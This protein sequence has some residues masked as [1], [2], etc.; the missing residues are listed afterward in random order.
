MMEMIS[1]MRM[2]DEFPDELIWD[3]EAKEYISL[4]EMEY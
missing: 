4:K 2:V 1:M 3:D